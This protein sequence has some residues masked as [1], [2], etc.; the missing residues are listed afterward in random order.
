MFIIYKLIDYT[1]VNCTQ[2][3]VKCFVANTCMNQIDSI[4]FD[5][6]LQ[7]GTET[8]PNKELKA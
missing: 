2:T 1:C 7:T 5:K 8:L 4:L 3:L 6:N